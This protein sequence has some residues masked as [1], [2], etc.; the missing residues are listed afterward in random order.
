MTSACEGLSRNT[1]Q[2]VDGTYLHLITT[3]G[4]HINT[5]NIS[6]EQE[7]EKFHGRSIIV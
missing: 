1:L 5:E 3:F 6:R 4:D 2:Q 7:R